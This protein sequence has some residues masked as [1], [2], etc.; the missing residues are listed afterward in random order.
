MVGVKP[1]GQVV[2]SD[3]FSHNSPSTSLV[4]APLF[5]LYCHKYTESVSLI[6]LVFLLFKFCFNLFIY[7]PSCS[8]LLLGSGSVVLLLFGGG[9]RGG[10]SLLQVE[11]LLDFALRGHR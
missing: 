3:I 8:F 6:K 10:A 7:F 4:L 5:S 2:N 11:R 1:T 9:S